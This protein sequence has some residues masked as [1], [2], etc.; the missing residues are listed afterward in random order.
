MKTGSTL[1]QKA[2][3]KDHHNPRAGGYHSL[4][5]THILL[6]P[7]LMLTTFPLIICKEISV[8][9][10]ILVVTQ[11][12]KHFHLWPCSPYLPIWGREVWDRK[13]VIGSCLPDAFTV[14]SGRE[15]IPDVGM[16]WMHLQPTA[17]PHIDHIGQCLR[18]VG[19]VVGSLSPGAVGRPE[20]EQTLQGSW[21]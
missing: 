1:L 2:G 5:P 10:H 12:H 15:W 20:W 4:C 6:H 14:H 18:W 13:D 11:M 9:K 16:L 21:W 8:K 3:K 7:C 19:E 17:R